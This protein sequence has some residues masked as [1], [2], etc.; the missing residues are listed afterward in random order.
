MGKVPSTL[1]KSN[2]D[3]A[4]MALNDDVSAN[5]TIETTKSPIQ[6]Y[7]ENEFLNFTSLEIG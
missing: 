1:S 6:R 3:D 5:V 7:V 2:V 4:L